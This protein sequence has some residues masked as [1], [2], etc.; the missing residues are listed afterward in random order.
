MAPL[1]GRPS[2]QRWHT[3]DIEL[4][5]YWDGWSGILAAC[6]EPLCD[7]S[8][9]QGTAGKA[10]TW[11]LVKPFWAPSDQLGLTA[12]EVLF[13]NTL[14]AELP[15]ARHLGNG[16]WS[17]AVEAGRLLC[18]RSSRTEEQSRA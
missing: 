3:A 14:D 12:A 6:Y 1:C 18:G 11:R 10:F 17:S 16:Q 5:L 15:R 8:G 9:P 2:L 7:L 13:S 4:E